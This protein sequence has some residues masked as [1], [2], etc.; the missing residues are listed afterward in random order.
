MKP[1]AVMRIL[2]GWSIVLAATWAWAADGSAKLTY[3]SGKDAPVTFSPIQALQGRPLKTTMGNDAKGTFRVAG[4]DLAVEGRARGRIHEIGLDC[5]GDGRIVGAEWKVIPPNRCVRF[6]G[7]VGGREFTCDFFDTQVSVSN[8]TGKAFSLW[9]LP[10]V[11]SGMTGEIDGVPVTIFDNRLA[12]QFTVNYSSTILIGK[13]RVALPLRKVHRIGQHRYELR[14]A[15]DGSR[16]DYRQLPD[17]PCGLVQT[18]FPRKTVTGLV[19]EGPAGTYDAAV[20]PV[21]AG[22]YR[23]VYGVLGKKTPIF[24]R[25]AGRK[26]RAGY[27]IQADKL[28]ILKIGPPIHINMR[29]S[30]VGM[31]VYAG[32]SQGNQM[33]T[34]CGGEDYMPFNFKDGSIPQPVGGIR[35]GS[36][37]IA[38]GPMK[39]G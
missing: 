34:G 20:D 24:F 28:N 10:A 2:A 31:T 14:A 15:R 3:T 30:H 25:L 8:S 7:K 12:E 36:R 1:R 21:P 26:A 19:L 11:R 33:V 16:I 5:N 27:E 18:R 6:S 4:Q 37:M 29:V 35:I 9:A 22:T 23:L 38:S 32:I 13:S 39:P 17:A